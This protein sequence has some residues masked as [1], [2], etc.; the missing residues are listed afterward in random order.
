MKNLIPFFVL[1]MFFIVVG[2]MV[3]EDNKP[4]PTIDTITEQSAKAKLDSINVGMDSLRIKRNIIN[5]IN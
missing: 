1:V 4:R 2:R 5:N 3:D